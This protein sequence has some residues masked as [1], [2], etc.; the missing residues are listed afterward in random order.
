MNDIVERLE[1]PNGPYGYQSQLACE[2]SECIKAL[3]KEHENFENAFLD[4]C[5][6]YTKVNAELAAM[7]KERDHWKKHYEGISTAGDSLLEIER[8]KVAELRQE[9]CV[10]PDLQS[11]WEKFKPTATDNFTSFVA[12][13]LAHK[14][15]LAKERERCAK[16]CENVRDQDA[17]GGND[18]YLEGRQMG[19]TVCMNTIRALTDSQHNPHEADDRDRRPQLPETPS[20]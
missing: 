7:K 12:G 2:A 5:Q 15:S 19:A 9:H 17:R 18:S 14:G 16:V 20:A 3:R 11:A 8:R 10:A 4:A 13:W 1:D 6:D